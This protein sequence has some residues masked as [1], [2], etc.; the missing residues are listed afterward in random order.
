MRAN[1]WT[2]AT[3][4]AVTCK[5]NGATLN[6]IFG[7]A[8]TSRAHLGTEAVRKCLLQVIDSNTSYVHNIGCAFKHL[9]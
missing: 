8:A 1:A 2:A 3:G 4:I 7:N 5:P 6:R 9:E